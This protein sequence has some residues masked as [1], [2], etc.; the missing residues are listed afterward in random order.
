MAQTVRRSCAGLREGHTQSLTNDV[1]LQTATGAARCDFAVEPTT[2]RQVVA[3]T[4]FVLEAVGSR[5]RMSK[6]IAI[7][8]VPVQKHCA[9][10]ACR[11]LKGGDTSLR[12]RP[13]PVAVLIFPKLA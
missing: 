4:A 6:N 12:H 7:I 8:D 5:V 10:S 3:Q 2:L 11:A 9:G 1:G 13:N